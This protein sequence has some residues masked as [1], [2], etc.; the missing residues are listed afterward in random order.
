MDSKKQIL[1]G[2]IGGTKSRVRQRTKYTDSQKIFV[3]RKE[4]PKEFSK[5]TDDRAREGWKAKIADV[6]N[7]PG[8]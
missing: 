1:S 2:E 3:T 6:C 4:F 7:R 8:S 5:G